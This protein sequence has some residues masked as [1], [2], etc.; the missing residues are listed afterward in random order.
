MTAAWFTQTFPLPDNNETA[1][2]TKQMGMNEAIEKSNG[3]SSIDPNQLRSS[4]LLLRALMLV[5]LVVF[6]DYNQSVWS[7]K[8]D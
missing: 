7:L 2:K 1:N 8:S 5:L 3:Y 4:R 6:Y